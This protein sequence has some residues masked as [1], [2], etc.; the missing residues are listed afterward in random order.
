MIRRWFKFAVFGADEEFGLGTEEEAFEYAA[1]FN[2]DC[3]GEEC[4]PIPL[5]EAQAAGVVVLVTPNTFVISEALAVI[6]DGH[7][8]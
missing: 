2:E 8:C 4:K 6:R 7:D 5:N 1:I 3:D